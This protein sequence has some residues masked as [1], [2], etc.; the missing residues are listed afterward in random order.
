LDQKGNHGRRSVGHG[1]IFVVKAK[2]QQVRYNQK[3]MLSEK[4]RERVEKECR[5][6]D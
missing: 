6:V 3:A 2:M 4:E 1:K 5:Q